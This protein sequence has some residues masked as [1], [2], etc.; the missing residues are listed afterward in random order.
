MANQFI[1]YR[2]FET[3]RRYVQNTLGKKEREELGRI[4]R[5][6]IGK[7]MEVFGKLCW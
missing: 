6:D 4:F 1:G 5:Q 7:D 3:T 2:Q